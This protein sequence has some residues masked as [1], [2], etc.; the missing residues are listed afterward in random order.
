MMID[1]GDARLL[2]D[3]AS[4][5]NAIYALTSLC[6]IYKMAFIVRMLPLKGS[7]SSN[8]LRIMCAVV[9]TIVAIK[10]LG[11]FSGGDTAEWF[12][13]IRELSW[14]GFLVAAI[15]ASKERFGRY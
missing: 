13:I 11:R 10:A 5:M 14:C 7:F 12:D 8:V 3:H 4:R 15:V 2:L 1:F 6:I 9:A